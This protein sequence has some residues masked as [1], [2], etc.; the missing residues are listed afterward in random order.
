MRLV[1]VS[2]LS[3][4][5]KSVAINT[6]EDNDFYCIDNMPLSMLPTCI[7][8]LTTSAQSFYEKIAIS[9]DARNI[10]QDI[11]TF[12]GILNQLKKQAI[13]IEFIYLEADDKTLIQRYSETRRK[14]PL[15]KNGLP[16]VE[17]INMEKQVLGEVSLLAD[18][19]IDTTLLNVHQLRAIIIERVCRKKSAKLTVLLQSFGFKRGVPNDSNYVFDVRCLPN[20]FWEQRLRKLTGQD[21]EVIDFLQSHTEVRQMIT[22][23][24]DFIVHWLPLFI[25]ENRSYLSISIG[26]T[27]GQHRSVHIAEYLADRFKHPDG[28]QVSV[29]HRDLA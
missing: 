14:H 8:H 15:T 24:G 25:K 22:S 6:L 13:D 28:Q 20:P 1:I 16:L 18:L 7:Q 2:G 12:T 3:G 17:A 27:S 11:Y 23:I 19:R 29:R 21:P 4:A 10:S 5:G 9:I 26:C